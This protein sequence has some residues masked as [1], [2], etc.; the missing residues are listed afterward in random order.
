MRRTM[1]TTIRAEDIHEALEAVHTEIER[2]IQKHGVSQTPLNMYQS[3][4]ESFIILAEEVGE[5]ARALTHD[6]GDP[7]HLE[8]ELIQVAA[9]A[10]AFYVG[11]KK[12]RLYG[13]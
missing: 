9:M 3:E 1:T 8:T 11:A 6:E 12:R 10:V 7:E 4:S 2:A 13:V 5:V